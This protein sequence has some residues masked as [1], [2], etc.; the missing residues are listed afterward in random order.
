[1]VYDQRSTGIYLK[2]I[3][4][5]TYK[6]RNCNIQIIFEIDKE[7]IFARLTESREIEYLY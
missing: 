2:R 5:E 4:L 7:S 6:K 3:N 1:M